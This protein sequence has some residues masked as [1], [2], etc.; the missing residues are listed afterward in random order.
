MWVLA[1]W[2]QSTL[3]K[4][5]KNGQVGGPG[6]SHG[7]SWYQWFSNVDQS[8]PPTDNQK[9]SSDRPS[10]KHGASVKEEKEDKRQE[11]L[12]LPM[13]PAHKNVSLAL[14]LVDCAEVE[15]MAM[16]KLQSHWLN[17]RFCVR[18]IRKDTLKQEPVESYFRKQWTSNKVWHMWSIVGWLALW[19][20]LY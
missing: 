13:W 5:E 14:S 10:C 19:C 1:S 17:W 9:T 2:V 18:G 11:M 3:K 15:V 7:L 6:M 16:T 20:K 12:L 8:V 4:M